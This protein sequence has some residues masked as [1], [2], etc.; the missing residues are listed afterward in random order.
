M[1]ILERSKT[2]ASLAFKL[3]EEER[4]TC[5]P[6]LRPETVAMHTTMLCLMAMMLLMLLTT[7]ATQAAEPPAPFGFQMRSTPSDSILKVNECRPDET[8]LGHTCAKA[9]KPVYPFETF[10]LRVTGDG[11]VRIVAGAWFKRDAYGTLAQKAFDHIAELLTQK[12]GKPRTS[13]DFIEPDSIWGEARFYAMSLL[14]NQRTR[15]AFWVEEGRDTAIKLELRS[16]S[17]DEIALILTY[18]DSPGV[19]RMNL[20]INKQTSDSL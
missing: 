13:V 15:A 11:I 12:W 9:P 10:V 7:N 3:G 20:Q 2:I 8:G 14:K 6:G 1:S 17:Y 18:E 16:F 19:A 4:A 5:H